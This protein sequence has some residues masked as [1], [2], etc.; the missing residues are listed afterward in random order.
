MITCLLSLT[1]TLVFVEKVNNKRNT[2]RA[3]NEKKIDYGTV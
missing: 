1:E 3:K 2:G